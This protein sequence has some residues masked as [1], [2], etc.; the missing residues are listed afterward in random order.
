MLKVV[1][2]PE[3][4]S[5]IDLLYSCISTI[6]TVCMI[7]RLCLTGNDGPVTA[8]IWQHPTLLSKE[9]SNNDFQ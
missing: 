7:S 3:K 4:F 1:R 2:R 5:V 8:V 9:K 6:V